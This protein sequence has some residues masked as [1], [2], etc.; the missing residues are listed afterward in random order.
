MTTL[1]S[2]PCMSP[3]SSISQGRGEIM[4]L[5]CKPVFC[6]KEVGLRIASFN[7]FDNQLVASIILS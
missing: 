5:R 7:E 6:K 4:E 3:M 1:S 2:T